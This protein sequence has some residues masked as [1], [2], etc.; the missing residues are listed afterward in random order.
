SDQ[1][2][3]RQDGAAGARADDLPSF[4]ADGGDAR[5]R[6]SRVGDFGGG[7]GRFSAHRRCQNITRIRKVRK[8]R[9]PDE[10]NRLSR[11]GL[12]EGSKS[13]RNRYMDRLNGVAAAVAE[14]VPSLPNPEALVARKELPSDLLEKLKAP[15][16]HQA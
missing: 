7:D 13:R 5:R 16:P 12:A 11:H 1:P 2:G 9:R 4:L 6:G 15:L 3:K 10:A 14:G 8:Q